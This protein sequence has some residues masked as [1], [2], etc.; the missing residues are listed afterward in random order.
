[1]DYNIGLGSDIDFF[2]L[3]GSGYVITLYKKIYSFLKHF[4]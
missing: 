4:K 1:M 2:T 3:L